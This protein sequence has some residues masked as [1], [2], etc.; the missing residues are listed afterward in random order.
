[1]EE[2]GH[3]PHWLMN[4]P[5]P[6]LGQLAEEEVPGRTRSQ[7]PAEGRKVKLAE[8][9]N[10][11]SFLPV[12]GCMSRAVRSG[13]PMGRTQRR[14]RRWLLTSSAGIERSCRA[15]SASSDLC[16]VRT[17]GG[18]SMSAKWWSSSTNQSKSWRP[19]LEL[20][21]DLKT[22]KKLCQPTNL[23]LVEVEGMELE[24]DVSGGRNSKCEKQ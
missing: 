14:G 24:Y 15:P 8:T 12:W 10:R 13:R 4:S 22:T 9:I 18:R 5:A 1:M 7:G 21:R 20:H 3:S 16:R 6:V 2:V 23:D 19:T 11:I 17:G